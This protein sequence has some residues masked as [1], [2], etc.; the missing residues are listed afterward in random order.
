VSR[1]VLNLTHRE[2]HSRPK[3]LEAGVPTPIDL[4]L[5][6]TSWIFESGHRLRL[7]LAGSDWPN[8]WPPP[9]GGALEVARDTVELELP[10]LDGPP[11]SA[12]PAFSPPPPPT[13]LDEP[14]IEQPPIVRQIARDAVGRQTRIV[15]SYGSRYDGPHDA[16]I[17][18]VYDGLVGVSEESPGRAWAS[19]RTRYSIEWPEASVTTEAHLSFR[20]TSARYRVV[21][22]VIA[23][24]DGPDGIGHVERRFE[25]TIP[26]RLQ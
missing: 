18:E 8:T 5:E 13:K 17:E 12:P 4:E 21:V 9:R 10:V 26:R 15:T 11:V 1:G 7:A 23:S 19:A 24:E 22:E 3:P 16:K 6:A 20:S 25:R 14:E 2:G